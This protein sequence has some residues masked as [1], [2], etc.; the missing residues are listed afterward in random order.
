MNDLIN[1]MHS[2]AFNL[3]LLIQ[4]A[5]SVNNDDLVSS[6]PYYTGKEVNFNTY[7]GYLAADSGALFYMF[8]ESSSDNPST[9]PLVLWLNGGP[10][11]VTP[12]CSS[13]L[14]HF[15]EL[16]PYHPYNPSGDPYSWN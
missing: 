4:L 15:I 5:V 9:D 8:E 11:W 1:I 2:S 3:Y 12:G 13:L 14:G 6:I 16:G 7:S 10:G